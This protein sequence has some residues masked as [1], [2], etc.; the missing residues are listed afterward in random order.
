MKSNPAI[1]HRLMLFCAW[2]ITS[3]CFQQ[4]YAEAHYV[5]HT[6]STEDPIPGCNGTPY[7][8]DYTPVMGEA[9]TLAFKVEYQF[10]TNMAAIYYTTDGSN[11]SGSFGSGTGSTQVVLANFDCTFSFMGNPQ[12][13]DVWKGTIP[14]QS[15]CVTVKYIVSAWHDGG[16][17]E[18]FANGPG[19]PCGCGIPTNNSALATVFSYDVAG[20]QMFNINERDNV[21]FGESKGKAGV[22]PLT[23]GNYSYLWNTGATTFKISNLPADTY[24]LTVTESTSGCQHH[25]TFTI[26]QP[27]EP[28]QIVSTQYYDFGGGLQYVYIEGAG[29]TLPYTFG[30]TGLV[31][32]QASSTTSYGL[33]IYNGPPPPYNAVIRDAN[34]VGCTVNEIVY[35]G[36]VALAQD[37]DNEWVTG[38]AGP[39]GQLSCMPNPVSTDLT[40]SMN[41]ELSPLSGEI[42]LTD[43]TG[44]M[45][46]RRQVLL[47]KGINQWNIDMSGYPPGWY[48]VSLL[49]AKE[50][51]TIPLMKQ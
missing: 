1:F 21:C 48:T 18:I 51:M 25:F 11:P 24:D 43:A 13:T 33:L 44:G 20:S 41:T 17:D 27:A 10:Y 8:S 2:S 37:D 3:L 38:F 19:S 16:G 6:R 30:I 49:T 39:A 36:V 31:P 7:V 9:V 40:L 5:Y 50:V 46:M 4:L 26:D 34:G 15:S 29:G 28:L 23:P 14:A 42:I 12:L 45:I 35:G 22:K 47:E 32:L